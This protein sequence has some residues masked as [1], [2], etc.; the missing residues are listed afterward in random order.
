MRWQAVGREIRP[1]SGAGL[2]SGKGKGRG[3]AWEGMEGRGVGGAPSSLPR[4]SS[5]GVP[6]S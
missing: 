2:L 4:G 6:S 1:S 3:G 5:G